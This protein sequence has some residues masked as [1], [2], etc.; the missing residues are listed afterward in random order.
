MLHGAGIFTNMCPRNHPNVAKY[1][2]YISIHGA[3][4]FT[5]FEDPSL[6]L[7]RF[8]K[9]CGSEDVGSC[10]TSQF[11]CG[12]RSVFQ[13]LVVAVTVADETVANSMAHE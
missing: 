2:P 3:Y 10:F 7:N 13:L 12:I 1:I 11:E 4:G 6:L 8:V 9:I 5:H